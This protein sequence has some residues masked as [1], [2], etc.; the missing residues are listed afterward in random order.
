MGGGR[1]EAHRE[2]VG[3]GILADGTKTRALV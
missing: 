1:S 3:Q 2:D